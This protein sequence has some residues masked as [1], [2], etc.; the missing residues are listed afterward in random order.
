MFEKYADREGDELMMSS[1][2]M[3]M[4][5]NE[6]VVIGLTE[7]FDWS[8]CK[9]ML[10]MMDTERVGKLTFTQFTVMWSKFAVF[11]KIYFQSNVFKSGTLSFEEVQN[12]LKV[13]GI[14]VNEKVLK[15]QYSMLQA[16][17]YISLVD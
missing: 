13:A 14:K 12:A 11:M 7:K 10:A 9:S 2:Q 1:K 8:G 6:R 15:M 3:M 17:S 5:L 4:L 16:D